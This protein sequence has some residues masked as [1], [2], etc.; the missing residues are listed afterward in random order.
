MIDASK[1]FKLIRELET[2]ESKLS[3]KWNPILREARFAERVKAY[4]KILDYYLDG[5]F[6][7]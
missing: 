3:K 2:R 6:D 4:E 1:V 5:V 7:A